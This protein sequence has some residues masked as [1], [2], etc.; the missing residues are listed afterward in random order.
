[1]KRE[2][3]EGNVSREKC[4]NVDV[5]VNVAV[6]KGRKETIIAEQVLMMI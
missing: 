5:K 4:Q 2:S 3:I 1:L 6:E